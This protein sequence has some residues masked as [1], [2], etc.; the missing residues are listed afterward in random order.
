ML[1]QLAHAGMFSEPPVV[2]T[3]GSCSMRTRARTQARLRSSKG[4]EE[5]QRKAIMLGHQTRS[6][7]K[8]I[9]RVHDTISSRWRPEQYSLSLTLASCKYTD[10]VF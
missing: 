2:G 7:D 1:S 3:T 4:T 10:A 6:P 8:S 5:S 9:T